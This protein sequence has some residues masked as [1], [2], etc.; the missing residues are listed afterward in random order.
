VL[1]ASTT[2]A[3]AMGVHG[4]KGSIGLYKDADLVIFDDDVNIRH[5]VLKGAVTPGIDA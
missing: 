1:M 3:E 5:V 2:P 4:R